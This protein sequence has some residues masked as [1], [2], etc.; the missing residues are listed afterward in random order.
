MH[1]WQA[2]REC[3]GRQL[4]RPAKVDTMHWCIMY[5]DKMLQST[6]GAAMPTTTHTGPCSKLL[7]TPCLL[8]FAGGLA[9]NWTSNLAELSQANALLTT[10]NTT[11]AAQM[12]QHMSSMQLV[13]TQMV[14][15]PT[16]SSTSRNGEQGNSS[17]LGSCT[18]PNPLPWAYFWLH[19]KCKLSGNVC[20]KK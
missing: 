20:Q 4:P 17:G 13:Q 2:H 10:S 6:M 8:Y 16:E 19:G 3:T 18:N 12:D 1:F 9:D 5:M 11:I 7:R 14:A 15:R